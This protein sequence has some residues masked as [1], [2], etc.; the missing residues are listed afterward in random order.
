ML[1]EVT[2]GIIPGAGGTQRL[3]RLVG[4]DN[5]LR[6]IFDAK[7]IE[8]PKAKELGLVDEII[9]GEFE[10]GVLRYANQL[11]TLNRGPRRTRDRPV[12]PATLTLELM[13]KWQTESR[14]LYP[15]RTAALTAIEAVTATARLPFD[16]GLLFEDKLANGTKTTPEAKGAIHVFFAE[17]ETRKID[18]LPADAG[19]RPIAKAG[20]IGAGTMGGGIAIAFANAGT[21]VTLLDADQA[22]LERGLKRIDDTFESMVKRGRIDA[23]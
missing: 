20:V 21:P 7:P 8:A 4:M 19:A 18:G 1:P 3:P 16:E 23:V 15:N 6:I 10:A 13:G 5:A 2:L 22:G 17:R 14:R 9:E 11:I 12:D